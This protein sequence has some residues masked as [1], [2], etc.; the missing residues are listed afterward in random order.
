[1]VHQ[2][3][4]GVSFSA[5]GLICA[6]AASIIRLFRYWNDGITRFT[7]SISSKADFIAMEG[8]VFEKKTTYARI[9]YLLSSFSARYLA[10]PHRRYRRVIVGTPTAESRH[11]VGR[12]SCRSSHGRRHRL[13][14][15]RPCRKAYFSIITEVFSEEMIS[16]ARGRSEW[17][18]PSIERAFVFM[19]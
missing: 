11:G 4:F 10:D 5:M 9:Y 2:S 17:R 1:M 7:G 16:G 19:R 12:S 14:R 3:P 15:Q 8:Y 18:R 13:C 6:E